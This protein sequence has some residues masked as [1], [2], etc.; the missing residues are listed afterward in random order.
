MERGDIRDSLGSV[1]AILR[2]WGG[3]WGGGEWWSEWWGEWMWLEEE[4]D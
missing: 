3:W 2:F 1:D 4:R